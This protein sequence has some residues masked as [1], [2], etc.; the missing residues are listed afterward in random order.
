MPRDRM[1][2]MMTAFQTGVAPLLAASQ[3]VN[4]DRL[5]RMDR[6]AGLDAVADPA[7]SRSLALAADCLLGWGMPSD[8]LI[9]VTPPAAAGGTY[10][11][12]SGRHR[13]LLARELGWTHV[14]ARVLYP[15]SDAA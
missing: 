13:A 5:V 15:R 11:W 10:G 3:P 12:T 2:A 9:A 6:A 1:A 4:R 8:D 14:P 7:N